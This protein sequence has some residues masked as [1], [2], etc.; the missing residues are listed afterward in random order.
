[1]RHQKEKVLVTGGGGFLGRAIVKQLLD[2]GDDV[3][4]FSRSAHPGLNVWK[5][6]QIQGDI[7]DARAVMH[8]CEGVDAVYHVAA[9]AGV[10]GA[11]KAYYQ[12]NVVGTDNVIAGCRQNKVPR[13]I[14]TSSPSVV[15][16]G[17]D[18]EGVD[19]S[20]PYPETYH[21]PYPRTKAMAEKRVRAVSSTLDVVCL[22]PHLIWGPGDNHLF[23]GIV[24]RAGRLRRIGKG[25]NRVD[26]VY[27][28][29][30]AAAHV[31][32]GDALRRNP[33]LSG[34][35]YFISQGEPVLLWEMVDR[36]LGVAG[37]PPVEKTVSPGVAYLAGGVL[38]CLFRLFRCK[39]EPPMTRFAAR[40]L[41]TSH[42]F[43]ISRA[44]RDLGY[45]PRVSTRE[46][47]SRM[48]EWFISQRN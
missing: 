37:L 41:A 12:A 34:N 7:A 35:V 36:F 33:S 9:R 4:S 20:V 26:T 24:S 32:A 25:A 16:D 2:R 8:A 6:R 22:R 31:L 17:G 23:P 19:E 46:G 15:F 45:V 1:M 47:L 21:A 27:V 39:T 14:Y 3:T 38:E 28:D 10:W 48:R 13:L 40:E 5:V 30:A 44:R 18:M 11:Y 42:W 29:N 43:D